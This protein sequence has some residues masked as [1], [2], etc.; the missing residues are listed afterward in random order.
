[1]KTSEIVRD[2]IIKYDEQI[3]LIMTNG[4]RRWSNDKRWYGKTY[5]ASTA[6]AP[7][8]IFTNVDPGYR[9]RRVDYFQEGI[10]DGSVSIRSGGNA[11]LAFARSLG[12][13]TYYT[14]KLGLHT[15]ELTRPQVEALAQT[16]PDI[17]QSIGSFYW[18]DNKGNYVKASALPSSVE[19]LGKPEDVLLSPN[20][21]N[22]E[23][24]WVWD[25]I[26]PNRDQLVR[27]TPSF[28]DALI[29]SQVLADLEKSV[30]IR[31]F[32]SWFS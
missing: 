17:R 24:R 16:N 8:I 13:D 26:H 1:M 21:H 7:H 25:L 9:L 23:N 15:D 18:F 2:Q 4:H 14:L 6:I 20:R 22:P 3:D 32:R 11:L 5:N 27:T 10:G 12:V 31:G 28:E 19:Y 29:I 30:C